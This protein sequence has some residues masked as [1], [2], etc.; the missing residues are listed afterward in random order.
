ME[1]ADVSD[2]RRKLDMLLELS[3]S[4]KNAA[5]SQSPPKHFDPERQV[6]NGASDQRDEVTM[7]DAEDRTNNRQKTIL[8]DE[9]KS[10]QLVE[11]Q[12]ES[13]LNSLS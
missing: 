8:H 6:A 4:Q 7:D 10:S 13:L 1:Q 12:A 3:A 11:Q 2:I 9:G 5:S